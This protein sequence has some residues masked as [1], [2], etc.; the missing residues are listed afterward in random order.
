[1]F[2]LQ[3]S[4]LLPSCI[5][6]ESYLHAYAHLLEC[7]VP[8]IISLSYGIIDIVGKIESD[9]TQIAVSAN[10]VVEI[11]KEKLMN[12]NYNLTDI[13][14]YKELTFTDDFMFCLVLSENPDLCKQLAEI[15][16][17]RKI[18]R[19]GAVNEQKPIKITSDGKGVRFD[20]YFSD[21]EGTAYDFEMQRFLKSDESKR[22]RYY[23]ALNDMRML[24][25]G[26]YYSEL[27]DCYIVFICLDDPFDEGLYKY[28]FRSRCDEDPDLILDDGATRIFLNASGTNGNITD[29][30]KNFLN[31]LV[32]NKAADDLTATIDSAVE[33][34]RESEKGEVIYMELA[35]KYIDQRKIG[36]A[37]GMAEGKAEQLISSVE[38]AMKFYNVSLE[39]ACEGAGKTVTDY[40]NAKKLLESS[41]T[42][43]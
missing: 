6:Q 41:K 13:K 28:T 30:V 1:M 31:Y 34:Q 33:L 3:L 14:P 21:N 18:A 29:D 10:I 26:H 8:F 27:N 2:S 4:A 40:Y 25:H 38:T 36:I 9:L 20:I 15:I 42:L 16:T 19:I 39:T 32:T 17:G 35:E 43:Y 5:H 23:Q 22:S 24:R 37:E 7:G 11:T 12:L